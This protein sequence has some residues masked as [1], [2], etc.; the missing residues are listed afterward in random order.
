MEKTILLT[1]GTGF[2]G[3]HTAVELL[4]RGYRVVIV[5]DLSNSRESVIDAL[6]KITGVRPAFYRANVADPGTLDEVFSREKI[7]AVIHLAGFKAVGESVSKPVSYY[8]NNI[9]TTLTLLETM[10]THGCQKIIFSSSATVYGTVNPVPYREEM[11]TGN[12]TNPYGW[13]KQMIEIILRDT[14]AATEGM[15]AVC[16][17]YFNPVGAHE[18]GLIGE[19]PNG[20]PNNLLPYITQTAAGIR[21]E[22]SVFGNDYD[23]PDGTGVRDYIHV[24][25]LA[26]GHVAAVEYAMEHTG[27]EAINL[28][29]GRGT[30]VLELVNAFEKVNGVAV[31]HKIA[32]RR[33][34]DLA[35]CYAATEKAERLLGW[36]ASLGVEDMV[37]DAWRWQQ[38][39]KE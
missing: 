21:K 12:C 11:P 32:P 5:D 39:C 13:T 35:T 28:G 26:R 4:T 37:R 20:I 7:D 9:D 14:A 8:R 25:D 10:K 36:K 19:R 3:S 1:G 31:P 6:E 30:S 18:S 2:I 17:R 23:T 22:L 24:V 29:T 27:W 33:P 16:L 15:S 34:G 38:N